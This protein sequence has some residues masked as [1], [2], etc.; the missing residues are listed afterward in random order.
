MGQSTQGF[1]IAAL[2]LFLPVIRKDLEI[3]FT[4]AGSFAAASALVYAL[5]QMPAGHLTD[6]WGPR[7]LFLVGLLGVNLCSL[8]LAVCRTTCSSC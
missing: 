3:R 5:M 2:G 1:A 4:E 7:R 8:V 6:R